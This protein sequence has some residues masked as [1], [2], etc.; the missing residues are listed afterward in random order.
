MPI[1]GVL[2]FAILISSVPVCFVW[3]FYGILAWQV[4]AFLNPQSSLRYWSAALNFPWAL[5][6]AIPTLSG[7]LFFTRNWLRCLAAREVYLILALWIWFTITS[8][9]SSNSPLFMHHSLLTWYH[10]EFVSKILLMT[11]A[12]VAIV[13]SFDRLRIMILVICGCFAY[14]VIKGLPFILITGGQFRIYGPENSMIADNNDF[15]LALN[16]TLPLFFLLA[17]TEPSRWMRWFWGSLFVIGI[18]VVLFTYSRGA[19]VGLVAILVLML[20]QLKQRL[21]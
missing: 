21:V 11:L 4:I 5:A 12:I 10:W 6:V 19:L 20:L 15:G 9:I 3:P 1:K 17:R 7:L 18:P 2:L 16:M 8:V 14:F 13:N